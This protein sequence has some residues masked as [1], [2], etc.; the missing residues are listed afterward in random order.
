LAIQFLTNFKTMLQK[1]GRKPIPEEQK[2]K[3]LI[4]YLSENQINSLGGK[5][6]V[7]KMLQNYS[8][9]K[10]KQNEKKATI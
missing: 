10:L 5:L 3:P 7:S 2:K 8:L 6:T 9:N 1:R 4:V